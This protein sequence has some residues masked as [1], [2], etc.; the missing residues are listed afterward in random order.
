MDL[1]EKLKVLNEKMRYLYNSSLKPNK[2]DV[3]DIDIDFDAIIKKDRLEIDGYDVFIHFDYL[4]EIDG[5][6]PDSF[7]YGIMKIC[8]IISDSVSEYIV[9]SDGSI[10]QKPNGIVVF[11]PAIL[12][13]DYKIEDTQRFKVAVKV[14]YE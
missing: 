13:F 10:K 3:I 14:S 7:S 5:F 8:N 4:G 2:I 9:L 11:P 1:K 12:Q 6:E